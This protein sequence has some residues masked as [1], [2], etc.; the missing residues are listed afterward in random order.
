MEG[1]QTVYHKLYQFLKRLQLCFLF[2]FVV[3]YDEDAD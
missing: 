3:K 2:I 1:N